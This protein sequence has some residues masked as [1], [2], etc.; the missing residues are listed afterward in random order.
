MKNVR[1]NPP[2]HRR[3]SET[4]QLSGLNG[5]NDTLSFPVNQLATSYLVARFGL[6]LS[7]ARLLADLWMGGRNH[8]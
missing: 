6:S 5:F 4:V 7:H 1:E 3:V 8:E 2:L